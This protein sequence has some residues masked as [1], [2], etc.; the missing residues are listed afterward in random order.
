MERSALG[1]R[2]G[3]A[4][5]GARQSPAAAAAV[6]THHKQHQQ[7]RDYLISHP[8]KL[9]CPARQSIGPKLCTLPAL[10]RTITALHI[11]AVAF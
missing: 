5:G 10:S 9:T 4:G 8:A 3:K 7:R 11:F 6:H 2:L 1:R